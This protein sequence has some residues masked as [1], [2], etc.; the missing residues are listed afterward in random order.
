MAAKKK[1]T[2]KKA[3]ASAR[4]RS[5]AQILRA[6]W[7]APAEVIRRRA[8]E[9]SPI[10]KAQLYATYIGTDAKYRDQIE[11]KDGRYDYPLL[12]ELI[13]LVQQRAAGIQPE[14]IEEAL[15]LK[16]VAESRLKRSQADM[17]ERKNQIE[18]GAIA[19]KSDLYPP[20]LEVFAWLKGRL[21]SLPGSSA[22]SL[23]NLSA[24][25]VEAGLA[26]ICHDLQTEIADKLEAIE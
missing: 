14:E 6:R 11:A 2:R 3:P 25:E 18:E 7:L 21:E 8:I 20:V 26:D 4:R 19:Y 1:R 15:Q 23:A 10:S 16:I 22:E 24:A 12:S 9:D 5:D 17:A 13:D